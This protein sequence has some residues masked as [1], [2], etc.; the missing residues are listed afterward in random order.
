MNESMS[1]KNLVLNYLKQYGP[2]SPLKAQS[3]FGVWRLASVINR[4]RSD[5]HQI[6]TINRR[7]FSNRQF[8]EYHLVS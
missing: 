4:L 5:G 1:Q 6:I 8:A 3:E 7:T 2:I